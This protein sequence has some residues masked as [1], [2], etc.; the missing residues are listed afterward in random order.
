LALSEYTY[1][2]T[3][4]KGRRGYE[5]LYS[6]GGEGGAARALRFGGVNAEK[7]FKDVV[8]ALARHGAAV[9]SRVSDREQVYAI[10]EDVGP[11]VGAY[12]LLVR[13]AKDMATWRWFLRWLLDGRYPGVAKA[14]ST[15]LEVAL[16]L[17]RHMPGGNGE[18]T[19]SPV[20]ADA[21]SSALKQFVDKI[22]KRAP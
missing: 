14:L 21:V 18:Y 6:I 7:G 15:F 2:L 13:R 11:V 9:P 17:S 3:L 12:L 10:R 8:D 19:I 16:E 22:I 1:Y 5:V 20:V 4:R